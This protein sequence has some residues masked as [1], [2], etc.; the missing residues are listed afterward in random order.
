[1]GTAVEYLDAEP[2]G[3]ASMIGELIESNLG[4][5]PDRRRLL[6]S[7]LVGMVASDAGVAITLRLAPGRV[8][9]SDG[10]SGRPQV[11]VA[12]DTQT[13]AELSLVPLRFGLPDPSTSEGRAVLASLRS[14][15]LKVRGALRHAALL[16]RLN[17]LLSVA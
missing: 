15:R 8:T 12:A 1:M 17:R 7:G 14:R 9:V 4:R 16:S 11:I 5:H 10:I 13:L 2:S 6:R 3:L